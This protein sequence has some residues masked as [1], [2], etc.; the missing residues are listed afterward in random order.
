VLETDDQLE[1]ALGHAYRYLNRR[2][3]TVSEM[4]RHLLQ[5]GNDAVVTEKA[6][7]TLRAESYLDDARYARLFVQDKR[8]LE[9]WGA[10]RIGRYLLERGID[11][12]LVAEALRDQAPDSELARA[13]SLLSRKFPEPPKERRDRDRALGILL[14]KGYDSDLALDALS[15]YARVA[16]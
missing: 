12:D 6:I 11:R 14:R 9:E 4:R 3:R 10:D 8:E 13:L 2:E 15:A 1:R 5:H 16:D 7:E